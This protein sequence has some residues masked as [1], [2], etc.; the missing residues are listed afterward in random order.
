M[1]AADAGSTA[2]QGDDEQ[3]RRSAHRATLWR[4]RSPRPA[5]SMVSRVDR[6]PGDRPDD[7]RADRPAAPRQA[8]RA[9]RRPARR[10]D[11]RR[12]RDACRCVD[13]Q[14]ASM[15]L[16]GRRTASAGTRS[17]TAPP[18]RSSPAAG[19]TSRERRGPRGGRDRLDRRSRSAGAR[20]SRPSSAPRRSTSRSAR[21][22]SPTSSRSR[23]RYNRA[24]RRVIEK[25]G[26]AY[27]RDIVHAGPPAC[28]LPRPAAAPRARGRRR[29]R[30]CRGGRRAAA[31]RRGP[32]PSRRPRAAAPPRPPAARRPRRSPRRPGG[33]PSPSRSRAAS[34]TSW[35][36]IA[37]IPTSSSSASDG[38][39]ADPVQP[40]RRDVEAPRVVRQPQRRAVVGGRH[41]L[42]RVP[43]GGVRDQV[44]APLGPDVKNAVPR[45]LSSHL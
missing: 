7:R 8:D 14:I 27:E 15:A 9:A 20:A 41:V 39:R 22:A 5:G 30:S 26:F 17:S 42:A 24:S 40:R 37:S 16:T 44:V 38:R 2:R 29:A 11:A 12:R 1:A 6:A 3:E 35:A 32:P 36:W 31:R 25:L 13:A 33:S 45:G 28:A 4:A 34:A 21:S 18:A 10:R 19:R 23:Y 43:A